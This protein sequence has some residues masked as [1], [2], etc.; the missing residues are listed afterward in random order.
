MSIIKLMLPKFLGACAAMVIMTVSSIS[1]SAFSVKGKVVSSQDNEPWLGA[2]YK[3]FHLPDT[4]TP[5]VMNVSDA[6]GVFTYE[7]V[8]SGDFLIS[9]NAVGQKPWKG[10]FTLSQSD[11][12]ADLGVISLL[13]DDSI[14]QEVTVTAKK[15]LV[16]SDGA[17]LT[18]NVEDDPESTVNTII[19]MLRKVP[20]VTVDAEDNIMVNG[21]SDFKI[22]ING[23]EDPMLSG[24]VKTILKSTPASA[25]KKIEVITEPGAKYDAGGTGGILNLVTIGKQNLAGFLTNY[26]ANVSNDSYGLSFYGRTKIQNVTASANVNWN[27]S[28]NQGYSNSTK[29]TIENI[30][31]STEHLMTTESRSKSDYDYIGGSLNLSWEPDTLNLF[32]V[33]GNIGDNSWDNKDLQD[34]RMDDEAFNKVW[35]L[36]RR[37]HLDGKWKGLGATASYQHT[38]G[39]MGHH[40]IASYIY[41]YNKNRQE[42]TNISQDFFNYSL[43]EPFE[44]NLSDARMHR[45]AAQLDYANPLGDKHLLEAGLKG[46]WERSSSYSSPFYGTSQSDAQVRESDIVDM[47]RLEDIMAAYLSYSGSY[48][49]WNTKAGLRY[50]YS[51]LGLRYHIGDYPDFTTNLNDL[52]PNAAVSYNFNYASNI[53]AAYQMRIQRPSIS[54]LNPYRN[55]M[56]VNQ[57]RYGNPDLESEKYHNV[58]V[59]YSNYMGRLSG[60]G[61]ISYRRADNAITDY[62]FF[63]DDILN[64]TYAN[65]GHSQMTTLSG[66]LQ[67]AALPSLNFGVYLSG[68]YTDLK[69]NSPQLKASNSGWGGNFNVN[70]DYTF[71]FRLRLSANGGGG[72]GWIDLQGKGSGWSFYNLSLSRSFLKNDALSVTAYASNFFQPYKSGTYTQ[73]SET[74]RTSV[75]YRFRQWRIGGSISFRFGALRSDVKRTSA[76]LDNELQGPESDSKISK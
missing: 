9:I 40:I 11:P 63:E 49:K 61:V 48:G 7:T 46:T 23:K 72:T 50:E 22:F 36:S 70:V 4:V 27:N 43:P 31:N 21:N 10:S 64:T 24:D 15:K 56:N 14:L 68:Y 1:I 67:W 12:D 13:P 74:S 47:D 29:S 3:I 69:A 73:N 76:I 19:E 42:H 53:R 65:I 71:P 39:R 28:I 60:S 17:T 54:R 57:V 16:Q 18:Y 25:V 52:V 8:K 37:G 45:H 34:I 32:T 44:L 38:F 2:T 55:T 33:Q 26:S 30:A 75:T 20:M 35:S 66:N 62:Q 5:L 6:E 59:S 41:G 51:R 58:S